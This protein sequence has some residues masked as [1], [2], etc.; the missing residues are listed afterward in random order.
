M[1][2][3]KRVEQG[4]FPPRRADENR[5]FIVMRRGWRA[6]S[7]QTTLLNRS[8]AVTFLFHSGDCRESRQSVRTSG[9]AGRRLG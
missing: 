3:A 1:P 7:A 2:A 5:E 4:A 6:R 8:S 9:P